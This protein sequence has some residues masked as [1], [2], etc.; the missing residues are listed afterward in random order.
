MQVKYKAS[1]RFLRDSEYETRRNRQLKMIYRRTGM[2][3]RREAR[4][5]VKKGPI[6]KLRAQSTVNGIYLF[7]E[8]ALY[9]LQNQQATPLNIVSYTP[10]TR[11][12]RRILYGIGNNLEDVAI[13][14]HLFDRRW[15][16]VVPER[17]EEKI[18]FMQK[19]LVRKAD[20]LSDSVRKFGL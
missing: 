20:A 10:G 9:A 19:A 11:N 18:P 12:L 8:A 2:I 16:P 7:G 4:N 13:G 1:F 3:I 17:V 14:P 5:I 6:D 15:R